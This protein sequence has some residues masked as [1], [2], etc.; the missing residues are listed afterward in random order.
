M[1][2]QFRK[3]QLISNVSILSI[4]LLVIFGTL[5]LTTYLDINDRNTTELERTI[6]AFDTSN[7]TQPVGINPGF[8]LS[9]AIIVTDGVI[10][11]EFHNQ[12]I[13]SQMLIDVYRGVDDTEGI[14][15]I[16]DF[17]F[18]YTSRT[19]SNGTLYVFIDITKDQQLLSSLMLTYSIIFVSSVIVVSLVTYYI[20]KKSVEPV[21]V[22]YDKQKDFIANASH[23]LKTPLTVIS[24]NID[25]LL[26]SDEFKDNKWLKYIKGETLRMNKLTN[27]LLQLAKT[28]D[29]VKA[30]KEVFDASS[31]L[32]SLL[33][34]VEAL[35]FE[36]GI[37]IENNIAENVMIEYTKSQ[38]TQLVL[39]L[40]DNAIKY[41]PKNETV[42]VSLTKNKT[43]ELSVKNTGVSLNE[44]EMSNVFE[45][46]FMTDE[47]REKTRNS[48][49]LGLSIAKEISLIN[50]S[51]LEVDSKEN[52]YT[53]FILRIKDKKRKNLQ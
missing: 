43:I 20:T 22:S 46:F 47:S 26:S 49:G 31:I 34:S 13:T 19:E 1:F 39:I 41:T 37:R 40:V 52:Q 27:D 45:R 33:L 4:I 11:N 42:I 17:I 9:F 32:N 3:R 15:E 36:K 12:S 48:F 28:S 16:D 8:S 24:S 38:F 51:D 18:Q 25:V 53:E 2:K 35:A 44:E 6:N 10:T 5:F 14:V 7:P 21:K 50:N 30:D 29:T 23:E